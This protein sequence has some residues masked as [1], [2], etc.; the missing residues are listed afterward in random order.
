MGGG[1]GGGLVV[2]EF[3]FFFSK[4]FRREFFNSVAIERFEA[5]PTRI[6]FKSTVK[7]L[8]RDTTYPLKQVNRLQAN[9]QG[10]SKVFVNVNCIIAKTLHFR[11]RSIGKSGFRF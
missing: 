11:V 9:H 1:G 4:L 6:Y 5:P 2:S 7:N 10:E 8:T 3:R